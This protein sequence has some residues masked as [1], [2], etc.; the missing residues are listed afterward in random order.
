METITPALS[1]ILEPLNAGEM[2]LDGQLGNG[3]TSG[4]IEFPLMFTQASTDSSP[5]S[6]IAWP[7]LLEVITCLR[8]H[9]TDGEVQMLGKWKLLGE[10]GN[11]ENS[12]STTPV[13]V[14]ASAKTGNEEPLVPLL[15]RYCGHHCFYLVRLAL[16]LILADVKCWGYGANG[17]LG[18]WS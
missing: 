17:Q 2:E 16:S 3:K 9:Q 5:L 4:F 15:T 8:S 6:D 1:L 13:S 12:D 18:Q 11:G 14:C 7:L 10:L